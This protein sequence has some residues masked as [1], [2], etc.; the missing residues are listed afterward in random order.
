M[1]TIVDEWKTGG[2]VKDQLGGTAKLYKTARG[3]VDTII[4]SLPVGPLDQPEV[5][6]KAFTW[7]GER[8]N[9]LCKRSASSLALGGR[10]PPVTG[11]IGPR[12]KVLC[13]PN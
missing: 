12:A 3:T 4:D 9:T 5:R 13:P 7:L 10:R 2:P 8:V 1:R 11:R 6:K